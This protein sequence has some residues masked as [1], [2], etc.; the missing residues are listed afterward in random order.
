LRILFLSQRVP[1]PPNRGDKITTWRIVERFARVHRVHCIA[2]AHGEEDEQAAGELR[3]RGIPTETAP[4]RAG[5]AKL[6]AL[7]LLLGSRPLTLGVFGSYRLQG[8]VDRAIGDCDLAYAYSSSMGAFLVPHSSVPR[9][10]HMAELDSDKWRQYA[11]RVRGPMRWVYA[12][13]RR[14]LLLFERRV[15][16]SF[17]MNVLCTPLEQAIFEREIPH[18]PSMVLRNGV[19]LAYYRPRPEEA[20]PDRLVFVGV[21]DYLPNVDGCVHFVKKVLPALRAARP[22]VRLAIVGSRPTPQVQA[23]GQEQGVEVAGFVSDTRDWLARASVSIAPLRIARGIQ[24]KVLEA[25]AMGLPVVGTT[26]ATQGVEAI[27][28]KHFL[29]ADSAEEQ[30]Q[31][32]LSLLAD[33]DK[34]RAIGA[35]ARRF[36]EERYDW[37]VTLRPLD[38]L[39]V[40]LARAK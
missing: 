25:F 13:E 29:L 35:A 9:I 34:A 40:R 6:K 11:E 26:S 5:R 10:M 8:M 32:I 28:G 24:N 27:A 18:A 3:R 36:V 31:A 39:L 22:N 33:R 1:Y 17:D 15:A 21:M 20:L 37:E 12:R 38:E 4:Y 19:D 30:A 23:L 14:T 7:P 2:F 16:T